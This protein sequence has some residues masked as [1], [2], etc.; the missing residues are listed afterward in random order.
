M[1]FDDAIDKKKKDDKYPEVNEY[2]YTFFRIIEE[3]GR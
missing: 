3:T 1:F 2:V